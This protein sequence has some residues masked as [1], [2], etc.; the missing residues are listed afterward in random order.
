MEICIFAGNVDFF[1]SGIHRT[2]YSLMKGN[3]ICSSK[4]PN[5]FLK[6][7]NNNIAKIPYQNFK[8]LLL[9]SQYQPYLAQSILW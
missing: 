3:Q 5:P 1:S 4:G 6:G 8:N 7:D 9:Q 2:K